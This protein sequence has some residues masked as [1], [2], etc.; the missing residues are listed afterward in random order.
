MLNPLPHILNEA[1]HLYNARGLTGWVT[2]AGITRLAKTGVPAL[3]SVL[4]MDPAY[5]ETLRLGGSILSANTR[6][7][8]FQEQMFAKANREFSKT[9]EFKE[10]AVKMSL[11]PFKLYDRISKLSNVAMWTIRDMMYMQQIN[12]HMKYS[13]MTREQA[14]KETE[15]HMPAY[16]ITSRVGEKVLGETLSR[17]LSETLQ[18]PN[19]TVFSRYHYGLVK[20]ILETGKDIGGI[21]RGKEGFK[22]FAHGMDTAAAIAVALAALYPLQDMIAQQLSGNDD[23]TV[24]RAGPYHIFHAIH[25]LATNEKDPMAVLSSIFTFNPALLSGAQ[26]IADRKLYNGQP[27]Y[28]PEDDA[29]KIAY[30]VANYA[31]TQ[32]PQISQAEQAVKAEDEGFK[33]WVARQFDVESPTAETVSKREKQVNKRDKA[34]AKRS[35][36]W[37]AE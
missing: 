9:P 19:V 13:G 5:L 21:R 3:K 37:R 35:E 34:G 12:E 29:D 28:H 23:A 25:D 33:Q 7:S 24:R 31:L 1:W 8:V 16:R 2:P 30:D 10:L 27:V 22:D 26:L 32:V 11:S 20:S 14:I 6:S 18:N 4:Q 17:S 36:R 15:R